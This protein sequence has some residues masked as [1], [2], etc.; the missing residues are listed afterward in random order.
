MAV[1]LSGQLRA[2]EKH[3]QVLRFMQRG[4]VEGILV[5]KKGT[6]LPNTSNKA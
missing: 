6:V 3:W 2:G 5:W 1:S 4:L